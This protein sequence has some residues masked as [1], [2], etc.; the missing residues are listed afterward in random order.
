M[1][2]AIARRSSTDENETKEDLMSVTFFA[3]GA[4]DAVDSPTLILTNNQARNFLHW[5]GLPSRELCG[6]MWAADLAERVRRV[7]H[8]AVVD[9]GDEGEPPVKLTHPSGGSDFFGG[10]PLGALAGWARQLLRITEKAGLGD[11]AWT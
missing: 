8:A 5:L 2:A 9:D 11:V 3:S 4:S 6:S 1:D 10:R 7:L